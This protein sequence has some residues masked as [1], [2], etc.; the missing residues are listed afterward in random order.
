MY[1]T[2]LVYDQ[3][4]RSSN[5]LFECEWM[6][7]CVCCACSLLFIVEVWVLSFVVV[8]RHLCSNVTVTAA[9]ASARRGNNGVVDIHIFIVRVSAATAIQ[10]KLGASSA[11]KYYF[12][13][14]HRR[15]R[16]WRRLHG[17]GTVTLAHWT[18]KQYKDYI[19]DTV[20]VTATPRMN[21]FF[22]CFLVVCLKAFIS[23]EQH[24]V[25]KIAN[26]FWSLE[27]VEEDAAPTALRKR[28]RRR[29][30]RHWRRNGQGMCVCE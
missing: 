26:F 18:S 21:F 17:N 28:Q 27:S 2:A 9:S 4:E 10:Q 24:P 3:I 22:S 23:S 12:A 11:T 8:V 16:G 25:P 20:T 14:W 5:E 1:C 30:K 13:Q 7:V 29:A 6:Y 19:N 15:R